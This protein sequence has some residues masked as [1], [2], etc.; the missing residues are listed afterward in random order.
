VDVDESSRQKWLGVSE[1]ALLYARGRPA[2]SGV[3][4]G[5]RTA[6]MR[7]LSRSW[8]GEFINICIYTSD[9]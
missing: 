8:M 3:A 4:A 9:I 6:A 5:H 7:V 2:Q 1:W